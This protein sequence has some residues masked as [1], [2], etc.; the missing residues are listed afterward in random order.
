M[1]NR[2]REDGADWFEAFYQWAGGDE[3]KVPW[4]DLMPHPLLSDWLEGK[5]FGAVAVVGC[6]L[7][8]D[9]EALAER[10]N[11][12]WAFDVSETVVE[13]AKRRYPES[14]VEYGVGDLFHL[15]EERKGIYGTVV[16]IFT[17][18][19]L[20]PE[21]RTE[22]FA[23]LASLLLP[24]GELVV[25]TRWREPETELGPVPWPLLMSEFDEIDKLGLERIEQTSAEEGQAI[26]LV[27]RKI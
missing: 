16:E 23:A 22:A 15:S 17:L 26:R 13:W 14:L 18:Q 7:G 3:E 20:P 19:A 27:W 11:S 12:V 5:Q 6:G 25:I 21:R 9:A 10:A 8:D 4:A 2:A 24:Q 1:A